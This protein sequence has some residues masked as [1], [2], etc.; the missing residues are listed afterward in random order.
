MAV[1]SSQTSTVYTRRKKAFESDGLL[2]IEGNEHITPYAIEFRYKGSCPRS[3]RLTVYL[4]GEAQY[5]Y[6]FNLIDSLGI[7]MTIN[8]EPVL[9]NGLFVN[10]HYLPFSEF[11]HG[12]TL[13]RGSVS[14]RLEHTGSPEEVIMHYKRFVYPKERDEPL[15]FTELRK[16]RH[17]QTD[18]NVC[19]NGAP[20]RS[21]FVFE[22]TIEA[23]SSREVKGILFDATPISVKVTGETDSY[24]EQII[25]YD[26]TETAILTS[27]YRSAYV[28]LDGKHDTVL[29]GD[30]SSSVEHKRFLIEVEHSGDI[31]AYA[32]VRNS[33]N[34]RGVQHGIVDPQTVS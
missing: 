28:P 7:E 9:T 29:N 23:T 16:C 32:V 3:K 33:A 8:D 14:F 12:E 26:V 24:S 1:L 20:H 13:P 31:E 5:I 18:Y 27:I 30:Y 10:F 34:R 6:D 15:S 4:N 19:P 2:E 17:S 25:D 22:D 21:L 11:H